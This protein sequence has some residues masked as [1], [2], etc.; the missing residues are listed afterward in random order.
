M[1]LNTLIFK[2]QKRFFVLH[3]KSHCCSLSFPFLFFE[4]DHYIGLTKHFNAGLI[5]CSLKTKRLVHLR[6]KVPENCVIGLPLNVPIS[7]AQY[8]PSLTLESVTLLHANHTPDGVTFLFKLKNGQIHWH[9]GDFRYLPEMIDNNEI[10]NNCAKYK[11]TTNGQLGKYSTPLSLHTLYLDTTYCNP[12]Y[13][14]PKQ[15]VAVRSVI[16]YIEKIRSTTSSSS[17]GST[18][19]VYLFGTYTI[20]KEKVFC[21]VCKHF[22]EKIVVMDS[23]KKKILQIAMDDYDTVVE[24]N[25]TSSSSLFVTSMGD[26]S[27]EKVLD[28]VIRINKVR[29]SGRVTKVYGFKPTGWAHQGSSSSSSKKQQVLGFK[30]SSSSSSSVLPVLKL[31]ERRRKVCDIDVTI[32]S[33]PY[34]EHSSFPELQECVQRLGAKRVLPTVGAFSQRDAMVQMLKK[35]K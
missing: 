13:D 7:L 19:T 14:L 31:Q 22:N 20:G 8:D 5:F 30:S 6:L 26:L 18:S 21:G 10:L 29:G 3:I 27:Y 28:V 33:V 12:K 17:G 15:T 1:T 4:Q 35:K 16:K 23:Q 11:L 34:S 2:S 24:K 32:V 25:P 9:T